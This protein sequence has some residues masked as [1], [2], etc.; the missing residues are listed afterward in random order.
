V[1]YNNSSTLGFYSATP[2]SQTSAAGTATGYAAGATAGTFHTDDTYTGNV[3]THA[4]TVNGIVAALKNL[5]LIA[6]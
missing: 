2:V 3:G 6:S 1:V 4:Y 5:G